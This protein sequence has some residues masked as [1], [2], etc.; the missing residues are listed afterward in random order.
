MSGVLALLAHLF[1]QLG[2]FLGLYEPALPAPVTPPTQTI[3]LPEK[4]LTNPVISDSQTIPL[5]PPASPSPIPWG[6]TEKIGDHLY[7]TY[8][9]SDDKMGTPEEILAA[10]NAYRIN[11][12]RPQLASDDKLCGFA[13]KRAA[14]QNKASGLDSHKGFETYLDDPNHWVE[15]NFKSLGENASFGYVLSGVHLIEWVFDADDEHRS[16]QLNPNWTHV[17]PAVS[18]TIVNIIFGQR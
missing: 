4:Q 15:L 12:S 14:E 5:P 3:T 1:I 9:G 6:T 10:L 2:L 7:R 13:N 8:V 16:N 18:G 11:H 17:C